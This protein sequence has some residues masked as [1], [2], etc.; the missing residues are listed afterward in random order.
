MGAG[1]GEIPRHYRRQH[2]FSCQVY[3]HLQ[4]VGPTRV[5]YSTTAVTSHELRH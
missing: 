5:M 4:P 2:H 1:A 3:T